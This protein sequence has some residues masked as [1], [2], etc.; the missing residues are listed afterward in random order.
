[1]RVRD[2]QRNEK[3][4]FTLL[5][6]LFALARIPTVQLHSSSSQALTT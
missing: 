3:L 1:M 5:S 6:L 2:E 4:S